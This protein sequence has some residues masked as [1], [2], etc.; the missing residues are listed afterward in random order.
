MENQPE[1]P[2]IL[3]KFKRI[4]G[5]LWLFICAAGLIGRFV[6]GGKEFF[7]NDYVE[8]IQLGLL[9][10]FLI[11]QIT[12]DLIYYKEDTIKRL[13]ELLIPALFGVILIT[14]YFY[15]LKN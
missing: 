12:H 15:F 7:R 5:F 10:L 14:F 13:K 2:W 4:I 11:L 9:I 8:G 6:T 3:G 1:K